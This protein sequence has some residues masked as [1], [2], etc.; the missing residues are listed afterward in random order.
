MP[1]APIHSWSSTNARPGGGTGTYCTHITS[2]SAKTSTEVASAPPLTSR[3]PGTNASTAPASAGRNVRSDRYGT[4]AMGDH[5]EEHDDR[6]DERGG[7]RDGHGAGLRDPRELA[8]G[9]DDEAR[10]LDH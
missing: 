6:A 3:S 7:R 5:P 4:S 2:E 10:A 1:S 8:G 9:H